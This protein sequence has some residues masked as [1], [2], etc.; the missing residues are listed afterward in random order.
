MLTYPLHRLN[1]NISLFNRTIHYHQIKLL[2]VRNLKFQQI[3][4]PVWAV[5]FALE[6]TLHVVAITVF[7]YVDFKVA[8]AYKPKKSH[9]QILHLQRMLLKKFTSRLNLV[10]HQNP[11]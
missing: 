9:V 5:G 3:P 10:A 2:I 11:E 1:Q 6:Q 8:S 4:K 7:S